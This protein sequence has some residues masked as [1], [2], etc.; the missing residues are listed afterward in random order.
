LGLLEAWL[1]VLITTEGEN[2]F[3]MKGILSINNFEERYIIQ[4]VHM[5]LEGKFD[6]AW[7]KEERRNNLVFIGRNLNRYFLNIGFKACLA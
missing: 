5:L 2:I 6:R 1:Q 3:R 7:G 4:G